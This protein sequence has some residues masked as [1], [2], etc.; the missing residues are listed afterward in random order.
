MNDRTDGQRMP[1]DTTSMLMSHRQG[2]NALWRSNGL[3][4]VELPPAAARQAMLG[5]LPQP[6]HRAQHKLW[7]NMKPVGFCMPL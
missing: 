7:Y 5:Q 1:A 2:Q 4:S 6:Q 3:G